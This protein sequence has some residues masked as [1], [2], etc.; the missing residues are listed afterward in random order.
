MSSGKQGSSSSVFITDSIVG[1]FK[2][3]KLFNYHQE[4]SVTS[5]DFNVSGQYLISAGI[6]KSIQLYDVHRG[7]HHKDIQSQKY[8]AHLARFA[9]DDLNCLYASTPSASLEVDHSIRYLALASN[10]YLR[11]FKGHK[12][13]VVAIEMNPVSETF[14]S[15]SLD[16]TVK[17]WDLKSASPIGNFDIGLPSVI[18][19]DPQGIVFAVGKCP[20]PQLKSTLGSVSLYDMTNFDKG[21][22]L[23]VEV[24]IIS[25]Q[26]WNKLEFSN[27]DAF[28]GQLLT[29]LIVDVTR[30]SK[31]YN[32]DWM[33]F[34]YPST[35]STCFTP[36][37]KFVLAG[38][39]KGGVHVVSDSDNPK[40][41]V[42]FKMLD[43]DPS[44]IPKILSFNPKLL[45]F[46]SADNKVALWQADHL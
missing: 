14:I 40:R 46:A 9:H 13:Q 29:T 30:S 42:P 24:P 20:Q 3:S 23:T 37:G 28:L 31:E 34:Q 6:D 10:T 41:T 19:F 43:T 39:P 8:G 45:T 32:G 4:A 12:E 26:S 38:S 17:V 11:Y 33:S 44:G 35:G 25:G 22:F 27:N 16:R 21:P 36:C 1:S 7:I 15:S 5:L 2:P 18:A